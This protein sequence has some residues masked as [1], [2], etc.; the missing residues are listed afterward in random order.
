M[1]QCGWTVPPLSS[2]RTAVGDSGGEAQLVA[3]HARALLPSA[4]AIVLLLE[5]TSLDD[6][7]VVRFVD[8]PVRIEG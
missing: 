2:G 7:T 8:D 3:D 5:G 1:F 4:K 6:V